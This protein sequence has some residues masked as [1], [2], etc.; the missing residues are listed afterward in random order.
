MHF[1]SLMM[2]FLLTNKPIN[3]HNWVNGYV[4]LNWID[5]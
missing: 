5:F 3:K 4:F 2:K 1:I